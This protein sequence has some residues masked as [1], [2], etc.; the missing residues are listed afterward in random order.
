MI[1]V[2]HRAFI[3]RSTSALFE[4]R[5]TRHLFILSQHFKSVTL[6]SWE[7]SGT[8]A[9]P[10]APVDLKICN[11]VYKKKSNYGSGFH[12]LPGHI[13]F[14]FFI[15]VQ[16]LRKRPRIIVACDFDTFF[17]AL[18]YCSIFRGLLIYDQFDPIQSRFHQKN[19]R[20]FFAFLELITSLMADYRIAANILRIPQIFRSRWME[21]GNV[22][23][24]R[25]ELKS[26]RE[27]QILYAGVLQSDRNLHILKEVVSYFP[28]IKFK[29]AGFGPLEEEIKTFC[30]FTSNC[31][32]LGRLTHQEV[33]LETSKS[34]AIWAFYDTKTSGNV[35]TASNKLA[36]ACL[37]KTPLITNQGTTLAN[38]V[39]S[40][41][42]GILSEYN[43]TLSAVNAIKS[44][45]GDSDF[46]FNESAAEQYLE[47]N[48]KNATYLNLIRN[49]S[50]KRKL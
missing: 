38:E 41:S 36:E 5:V 30:K 28:D 44:I 1:T 22:F 29:I 27:N 10:R 47:I 14:N 9:H 32:F 49:F 11:R 16:L 20:I 48:L 19:V 6:I 33:L 40:K 21:M 39:S 42:L 18:I 25:V 2:R 46:Q 26:K 35:Y 3:L 43:N 4:Q 50:S 7:R 34:R 15:F 31:T 17:P 37:T 45:L 23:D 13:G 24:N 8:S 12:S